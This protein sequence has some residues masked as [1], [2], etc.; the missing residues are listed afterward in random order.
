MLHRYWNIVR[1]ACVFIV[2]H[3]KKGEAYVDC[4]HCQSVVTRPNPHLHKVISAGQ[5]KGTCYIMELLLF[6]ANK[7]IIKWYRGNQ[8]INYCAGLSFSLVSSFRIYFFNFV[9]YKEKIITKEANAWDTLDVWTSAV[10]VR[11][12]TAASLMLAASTQEAHLLWRF[13]H[14]QPYLSRY[15]VYFCWE[16]RASHGENS[17]DLES[18]DEATQQAVWLLLPV[19]TGA[20][21][22]SKRFRDA[23]ALLTHPVC[24]RR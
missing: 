24:P 3:R 14:W 15:P 16:P 20:E 6:I 5:K 12:W 18:Q 13:C 10:G 1:H 2:W 19:N 22:K 8:Y 17:R 7:L 4:P 11:C 9:H 21:M 23:R